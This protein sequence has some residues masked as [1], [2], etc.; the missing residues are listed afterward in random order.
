MPGKNKKPPGLKY[1]VIGRSMLVFIA[2][3]LLTF[4]VF[5]ADNRV[6]YDSWKGLNGDDH[7]RY[8]NNKLYGGHLE[9]N[10]VIF[11]LDDVSTERSSLLAVQ[12]IIDLFNESNTHLDVGV[13]PHEVGQD[14]YK[15][16]FIKPYVQKGLIGLSIHGYG[17]VLNEF[18]TNYSKRTK[19]ELSDGLNASIINMEKYFG[20]RPISFSV[21]YDVFDEAGFDAVRD[22]GL[23]I[24]SSQK[25]S[26]AHPSIEPVGFLG[27]FDPSR[28]L[29]RLPA[30]IS[31]NL[32]DPHSQSYDGM[33]PIGVFRNNI[34]G[35]FNDWG[36]AIVTIE[37]QSFINEDGSVKK[38]QIDILSKMI[39][40]SKERGTST[41]FEK[42][43]GENL[44]NNFIIWA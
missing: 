13:I 43:Y 9:G 20:K 22:S 4:G 15:I 32:W 1:L 21:P 40:I 25:M 44:R 36:F 11:R 37:P 35:S 2:L 18:N 23:K 31:V 33:L 29:Y 28:G 8:I 34:N 14:S 38:A 19:K 12:E 10:K 3:A 6:S 42:L 5:A 30:V 39:I 24:F 7:N 16:S 41:T 17:H 27:K 26:E